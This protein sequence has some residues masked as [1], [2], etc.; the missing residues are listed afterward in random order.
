MKKGG[1]TELKKMPPTSGSTDEQWARADWQTETWWV[2]V[3]TPEADPPDPL[4]GDQG[5]RLHQTAKGDTRT[6]MIGPVYT[7]SVKEGHR[8]G[9]D[10][11]SP[12]LR[13]RQGGDGHTSSLLRH[14]SLPVLRRRCHLH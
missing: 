10:S 5:H 1:L 3:H 7:K 13:L 12:R 11:Q 6:D 4:R 2:S 9:A 14:G 8:T